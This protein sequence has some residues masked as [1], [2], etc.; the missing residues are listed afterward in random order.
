[1]NRA[2]K[3]ILDEIWRKV[4]E[5]SVPD[6][7]KFDGKIISTLLKRL[8]IPDDVLTSVINHNFSKECRITDFPEEVHISLT[9]SDQEEDEISRN[10]QKEILA[11]TSL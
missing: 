6:R 9:E 8:T 5:M 2:K 3:D 7:T 1:M 4:K 10:I 11:A